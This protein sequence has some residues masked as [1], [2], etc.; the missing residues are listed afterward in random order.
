M[1]KLPYYRGSG[2]NETLAAVS[3]EM[4]FGELRQQRLRLDPDAQNEA[5]YYAQI[6]SKTASFL[7]ASCRTG[8]L[9]GGLPEDAADRLGLFGERFGLAF[10]ILDDMLDYE[11][12]TAFG[13]PSG[14]DLRNGVFTLPLLLCRDEWPEAARRLLSKRNKTDRDVRRI[15]ERVRG[16][17]AL[18]R[19]AE[20]I[21]LHCEEASAALEAPGPLQGRPEKFALLRLAETLAERARGF[22]DH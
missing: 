10:Q 4:C 3:A 15:V 13:R 14:Q 16:A 22:C 2:I 1:E 20:K 17:G 12:E 8:A 18:A 9:A 11:A 21:S 6:R 19:A 5:F 7:S